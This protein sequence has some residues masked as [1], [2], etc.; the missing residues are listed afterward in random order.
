MVGIY[1]YSCA[2]VDGSN[3]SKIDLNNSKQLNYLSTQIENLKILY[4]KYKDSNLL[5]KPG[6]L[7]LLSST[8]HSTTLAEEIFQLLEVKTTASFGHFLSIIPFLLE[9]YSQIMDNIPNYSLS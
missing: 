1:E 5:E 2:G 8:N 3:N 7:L 6:F 9:N 4:F